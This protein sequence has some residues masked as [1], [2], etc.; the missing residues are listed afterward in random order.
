M[1]I[2]TL[3][4]VAGSA[5]CNAD[6]P[7]CVSKMTIPHGTPPGQAPKVD[8]RNL[9]KAI[10]L[11]KIGG[12]TTVLFTGKG[13]PTLFPN[14]ITGMLLSEYEDV[15]HRRIK[16]NL[17]DFPF[18][19]IQTNGIPIWTLRDKFQGHLHEWHEGGVST[20]AISVV[21]W[22]P[23]INRSIYTPKLDKYPV[24]LKGLVDLLH[25]RGFSV[26]LTTVMVRGALDS[27]DAVK[28]MIDWAR[29]NKVEQLTFRPVNKPQDGRSNDDPT[30]EWVKENGLSVG[31][32]R[33]CRIWVEQNGVKLMEMPH[34]ADVYDVGGQNVCLTDCLSHQIV[35]DD[36][37][38]LIYYPN[39]RLAYDWQFE[40]AV[41]L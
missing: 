13:E 17:T 16:T 21:H 15:L 5:A 33:Y 24:D 37:R 27:P 32:V 28:G 40:G 18:I 6:C 2:V 30:S 29:D 8:W 19:E 36:M 3:S 38:Q 14:H 22:E 26:R 39:G 9:E 1:K 31:D 20:I 11:A 4:I 25:E 34:G 41:L 7:F 12:C 23:E 35:K 10:K